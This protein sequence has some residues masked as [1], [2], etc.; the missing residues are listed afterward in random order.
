MLMHLHCS[1]GIQNILHLLI[2]DTL[3]DM[4][5]SQPKGGTKWLRFSGLSIVAAAWHKHN[6]FSRQRSKPSPPPA[7]A[8]DASSQP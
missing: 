1:C 4:Q 3:I 8:S 7:A 2:S 5:V 6:L